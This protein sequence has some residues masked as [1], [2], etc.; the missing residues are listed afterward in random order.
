[1]LSVWI[2]HQTKP[3]TI[4]WLL[5]EHPKKSSVTDPKVECHKQRKCTF[6]STND[7]HT[8]TYSHIST[9]TVG[10][11]KVFLDFL[12]VIFFLLSRQNF[13][14]PTHQ[15]SAWIQY[16]GVA[17]PESAFFC[18]QRKVRAALLIVL[19]T[20][21]QVSWIT[22]FFSLDLGYLDRGLLHTR[23]TWYLEECFMHV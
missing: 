8:Y 5:W 17:V 19:S 16:K 22:D 14:K 15:C 7:M 20:S 18:P 3:Q 6:I 9:H 4:Y 11:I 2:L 12:G 1:M 10:I 13:F 23:N 21:L